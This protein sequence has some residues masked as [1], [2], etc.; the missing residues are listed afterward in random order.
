MPTEDM[1]MGA[2]PHD[3]SDPL[4][5]TPA[6]PASTAVQR[7][8]TGARARGRT[9][10]EQ[11]ASTP[12]RPAASSTDGD[13]EEEPSPVLLNAGFRVIA[14]IG[15]KIA[16]AALYLLVARE[17]G[18]S[19]F[20]VFAFAMAFAGIAVTL[21]Q[22][23][24][25][26]VLIREVA[27]DRRRL[28]TYYS[29][30]L[31]SKFLLSA[32]PLL[33]VV[34]VALL[35]GMQDHT[36][37]VTLLMGGGFM[38]DNLLGASFAAFQAYER[39]SLIP[40]VLIAQ[41]W[42]TTAVAATVLVLGGGI[43]AVAG[44]YCLGA[45]WAMTFAMLLLY[46]RVARPRLHLD[47]RAALRLARESTPIGVGLVAL[48]L[49][50]RI[51]TTMLAIFSTSSE[52]GQYGAAYRLLE[53][54]AFVTWAVNTAVLPRMSRLSPT[55]TP[56]VG[57]LYGRALKLVLAITIPAAVGTAIL[58]SPI[59]SLLYGSEYHRAA[60][61]LALLA[62]TI[63]LF[64]VSS[65]SCQLF[66]SQDVRRVVGATY[67]AVLVEN[68]IWNLVMIPRFSLYGAAAGTSVSELLVASTLLVLSR[69]LHG[70]LQVTRIVSGPLLGSAVAAAVFASLSSDLFMAAPLGAI[71]YV[72]VFLLFE[73][74]VYPDDFAALTR[75]TAR[76]RATVRP[77]IA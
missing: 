7:T 8:R 73:R 22:F 53:A 74:T 9:L 72:G 60:G 43:V 57:P 15:S 66:Y 49:L 41:R 12:E 62:P 17:A 1:A 35:A 31:L 68:I 42:G 40:M 18:A 77:S 25:E 34:A 16:T 70:R 58:S 59:I 65:L 54:T 67:G 19:E 33:L 23:G 50:A 13:G 21:G 10:S 52:V 2:Q 63:M 69:P 45:L 28:D 55:S 51:D 47:F 48:V 71:A 32:P 5:A 14:D 24:Q 56:P 46:R 29:D 75:L 30:V 27:R 36:L 4:H 64:P 37:L 38:F 3:A 6:G 39:V 26:V 11:A 61:A 44:I 76:L 20:G